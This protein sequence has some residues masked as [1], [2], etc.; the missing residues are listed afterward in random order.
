MTDRAETLR[1]RIDRLRAERAEA[2][3]CLAA[4]MIALSV[5]IGELFEI[6]DGAG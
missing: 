1:S 3:A 5:T 2:E 6:E 4:I